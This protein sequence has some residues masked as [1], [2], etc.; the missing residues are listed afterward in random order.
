MRWDQV[1]AIFDNKLLDTDRWIPATRPRLPDNLRVLL[2]LIC[3]HFTLNIRL[4]NLGRWRATA[5][6]TRQKD[7][8]KQ[9]RQKQD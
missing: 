1:S 6:A 2:G 9:R 5:A 7:K 8:T 4:L 3:F